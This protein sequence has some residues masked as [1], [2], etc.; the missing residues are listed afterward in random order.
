MVGARDGLDGL[1]VLEQEEELLLDERGVD[2]GIARDDVR[3]EGGTVAVATED[4]AL[5]HAVRKLLVLLVQVQR[6]VRLLLI[7]PGK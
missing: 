7:A 5:A 4:Q 1:A 2:G 3:R 6:V